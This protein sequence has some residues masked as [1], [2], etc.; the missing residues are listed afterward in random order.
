M[1]NASRILIVDD[2][3]DVREILARTLRRSGF[4]NVSAISGPDGVVESYVRERPDLLVIDFKLPPSDGIRLLSECR[5]HDT[6][7]IH[8]PAIMLTGGEDPAIQRQALE[9]GVADFLR[10]GSEDTELILRVRN[11]LR[12]HQLFLEVSRQK[13]WLEEMVR[14]RT[15]ELFHARRDVLE[16]LAS[17]LDSRDDATGDHTK[18][19]G[20]LARLVAKQLGSPPAFSEAIEV[21]ALLHDVGKIAIP[22]A[23]LLKAGPLTPEERKFMEGH[24]VMGARILQGS[25]EPVMSMA[26]EIA[27]S[28][29]ERW[30]GKGY[31]QGLEGTS[32]PLSGR[33]V[34][35]IDAYDAMTHERP[36]KKHMSH[37]DSVME[38]VRNKGTQ[39]DPQVVDA[40]LAITRS[41]TSSHPDS[42][43]NVADWLPQFTSLEA[44]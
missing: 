39:F 43:L 25:G 35:V 24:C 22:D 3:A 18:R 23:I 12:S 37:E 8:T 9:A 6:D 34:A 17:A 5:E 7:G 42:Q 14:I 16:R 28:H 44:E 21:A 32:I 10:K 33:I 30:D 11:V 1:I 26:Y 40:F 38:L 2:D 36:Y 29:H 13:T 31:P 15:A 41:I 19:V 20:K 27:M 4:W